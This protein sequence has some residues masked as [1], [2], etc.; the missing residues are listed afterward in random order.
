MAVTSR[1]P[2]EF[3]FRAGGS[4]PSGPARLA[5]EDRFAS[6]IG[7]YDGHQSA[8]QR[9]PPYNPD[10]LIQGKGYKVFDS[11]MQ[12]AAVAGPVNL[13]REAALYKG[14]FL[15]P[16]IKNE[17]DERYKKA[18]EYRDRYWRIL[19]DIRT[20]WGV[21]QPLRDVLWEMSRGV[22][23][24]FNIQEI[25]PRVIETGPDKGK[26][27]L[28]HV[29]SKPCK[30]IAF[31]LDEETG[32]P[33]SLTSYIPG[34]GYREQVPLE[35]CVHFK[36]LPE[37]GLPWGTPDGRAIYKHWW[38]LDCGY[39]FWAIGLEIFGTPFMKATAPKGAR[40]AEVERI[41]AKIRQGSPAVFP[42]GIEAELIQVGTGG[43]QAYEAFV[44][45]H[46]SEIAKLVLGQESTTSR[47]A[48][49][50]QASDS[51]RQDTQEYKLQNLRAGMECAGTYQLVGRLFEWNEGSDDLDL[52]P[53]LS[54]GIWDRTDQLKFAQA[55][56][57]LLDRHVIH[58]TNPWLLEQVGAPALSAD[59][60]DLLEAQAKK[61]E[62][63]M[64]KP[65]PATP[66]SDPGN[67]G[68]KNNK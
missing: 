27:G 55:M 24:G 46:S 58:R 25:M 54:L 31:D 33:L 59:E 19:N 42:T 45:R 5:E 61:A 7:N 38:S 44:D 35:K 47:G 18:A 51:V 39:R 37:E 43:L 41:I 14:P 15:L 12:M 52:C 20:D 68:A 50:S 30:Q 66:S 9:R 23:T 16:A 26:I 57:V 65:S 13:K 53:V 1:K 34:K 8:L 36:Y 49:G 63:A 40:L 17:K 56:G 11:M 3:A 4:T 28:A 64:K 60:M 48:Q 21:R 22:L 67:G 62:E 29:L 2:Y 6:L 32:I 10:A